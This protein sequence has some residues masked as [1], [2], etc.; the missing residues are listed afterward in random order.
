MRDPKRN[1]LIV[2]CQLIYLASIVNYRRDIA[3]AAMADSRVY[4]DDDR[5]RKLPTN[6]A[7][8]SKEVEGEE[9]E[10]VAPR[11]VG[12]PTG[13]EPRAPP[14]P[15]GHPS[16]RAAA[17]RTPPRL[18]AG[19]LREEGPLRASGVRRSIRA[20]S[21]RPAPPRRRRPPKRSSRLRAK[22]RPKRSGA[23]RDAGTG[24]GRRAVAERRLRS[25]RDLRARSGAHRPAARKGARPP[26]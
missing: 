15:P 22:R 4:F 12:S 13:A 23:G 16:P 9:S 11:D 26:A 1:P 19:S 5:F 18:P 24:A 8:S 14:A 25:L 6:R 20:P 17:P 7:I 21:R 3:V 2:D 10:N